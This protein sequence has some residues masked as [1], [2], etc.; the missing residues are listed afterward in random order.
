MALLGDIVQFTIQEISHPVGAYLVKKATFGK[1][2]PTED[3]HW[4]NAF[5][6]VIGFL[7]ICSIPTSIAMLIKCLG[8]A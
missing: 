1:I 6:S 7:A 3:D 8:A 4:L 2:Q 5:L